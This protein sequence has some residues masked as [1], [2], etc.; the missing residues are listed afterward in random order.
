MCRLS[1]GAMVGIIRI[2]HECEGRIEKSVLRIIDW[3]Y[4]ACQMMTIGD[5]EGQVFLS[6][7]HTINVPERRDATLQADVTVTFQ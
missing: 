2:Y 1:H 4:E 5:Q 6:H 3:H 7:H